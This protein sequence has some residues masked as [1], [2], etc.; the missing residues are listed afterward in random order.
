[1][2]DVGIARGYNAVREA[3]L[4]YWGVFDDFRVDLEEVLH[5]DD[6][7][8]V[9]RVRDWGRVKGSDS[10]VQNR[11]FHVFTLAQGRIVR[12]SIHT[13]EHQALEAAGIQ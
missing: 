8:V 6:T 12:L 2:P 10:E 13:E 3:L 7:R 4:E 9:T 1:M 5:A 11:Y